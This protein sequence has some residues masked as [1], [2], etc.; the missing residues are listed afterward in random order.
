MDNII[1][2]EEATPTKVVSEEATPTKEVSEVATP[3]KEVSEVAT[4]SKEVIEVATPSKEVSEEANP[5]VVANP[6]VSEEATP[7]KEVSEDSIDIEISN[8]EQSSLLDIFKNKY[9]LVAIL[10]AIAGGVY[11][12]TYAFDSLQINFTLYCCSVWFI[13]LAFIFLANYTRSSPS[14]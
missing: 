10:L 4:P 12:I 1:N 8:D 7:T 11:G 5:M 3:S 14:N 9:M 13:C 2:N 6:I